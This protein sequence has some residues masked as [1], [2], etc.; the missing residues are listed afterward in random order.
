MYEERSSQKTVL[1]R[2]KIVSISNGFL[3]EISSS[4]RSTK[5]V[6]EEDEDI[7]AKSVKRH[8]HPL[9]EQHITSYKVQEHPL[10]E[11]QQ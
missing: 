10:M 5:H 9:M 8:S 4:I 7:A 11:S 6:R 1:V 2:I 3:M